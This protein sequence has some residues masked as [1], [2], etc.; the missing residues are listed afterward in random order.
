MTVVRGLSPADIADRLR[1]LDRDLL[2]QTEKILKKNGSKI[3]RD[4]MKITPIDTG[5]LHASILSHTE[6]TS[7]SVSMR[8][9]ANQEYAAKQH[10]NV[11][12]HKV[13]RDHFVSIPF[14]AQ[15]PIIINEISD[16]I[17]KALTHG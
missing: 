2:P 15:Y 11:Y 12:R 9:N 4:A 5:L 1:A 13:G 17:D 10:E 16:M 3:M 7:D 8:V 14:M 6:R